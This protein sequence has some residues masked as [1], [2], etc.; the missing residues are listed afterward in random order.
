M[1]RQV[2]M[3]RNTLVTLNQL[4]VNRQNKE[5]G[6]VPTT[7]KHR[8]QAFTESVLQREEQETELMLLFPFLYTL[9]VLVSSSSPL[10]GNMPLQH[11]SSGFKFWQGVSKV[12]AVLSDHPSLLNNSSKLQCQTIIEEQQESLHPSAVM[13]RFTVCE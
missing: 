10:K 8:T 7:L 1:P 3:S 13:S 4:I 11:P 9:M 2:A 6:E 5:A 12:F